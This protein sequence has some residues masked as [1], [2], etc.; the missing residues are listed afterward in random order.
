MIDVLRIEN[1]IGDL[2]GES[3]DLVEE[4]CLKLRV[5]ENVDREVVRAF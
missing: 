2:L 5:K 4:G 3:V 1:Q